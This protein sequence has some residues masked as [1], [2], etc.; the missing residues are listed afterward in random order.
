MRIIRWLRRIYAHSLLRSGGLSFLAMLVLAVTTAT[1]VVYAQQPSPEFDL[2]QVPAPISPPL[3]VVGEPI[4]QE[5]CTPCHGALGLGDGP[6]AAQLPSPATAFA[7]PD[8]VWERSP[9]Q[10]FHTTKFGRIENLMPPW[11]NRLDDTQI[12]QAVAYAWSLHTNAANTQAGADLYAQSCAGCHGPQGTG[13][14]AETTVTTVDFT[15][16][17]YAMANSQAD[18]LDGWQAAHS[19]VGA[20]WTPEQQRNVLEAV[21]T[22]SY[23]PPWAEAYRAGTGVITGTVTQGT[24][25]GTPVANLVATLE[26]YASFTLIANFTTTVESGGEFAFGELSTDPELDY[27]VVVAAEGIRYNSPAL[28]FT[29]EQS[30]L[31]TEVVIYATTDDGAGVQ[32]D[33][34]HWIVD[35][36][37]GVVA[38]F[39]IYSFGNGGDRTFIGQTV[40]GL[41]VPV[42]AALHVP[43]NAQEV[44]FENGVLGGRF[45]QVD[46]VVYDTAP[47]LPGQ[48]TQQVIMQ[49]L[50][51]HDGTTLDFAQ[52]FRYPVAAMNLL[53]TELPQLQAAVPGFSI[54][55]RETLEG[56]SYQL[57]QP[58]GTVP[59]PVA[60]QMTGLLQAGEVDPRTVTAEGESVAAEVPPGLAVVPLLQPWMAWVVGSLVV[61][62]LAT[63]IGWSFYQQ[64]T[65][66]RDRGQELRDQSADLIERIAHL[67]DRHAIRDLDDAT[68]QQERAQLKAQLLYVNTQLQALADGQAKP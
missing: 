32:I 65:G 10:L 28:G 18:W 59:S 24:A 29:P 56:Q 45:Q 43:E 7:D 6:T 22:F 27:F 17:S 63:I 15:N 50:L 37:P 16:L 34:L 39:E 41:D 66:S 36:R 20:D 58:D 31:Q 62:A 26:A 2:S 9:A 12:W 60:V 68:W 49:Y 48:G 4:Y 53:I 47:V 51:P 52:E 11:Q 57:W 55:R 25:A 54:T 19:D 40:D 23:T 46:N 42:T 67:D 3:A 30:A 35:S 44:A 14:G 64:R 13:D 61:V 5:N 33:Q 1:S 21:R 8:A 38:I